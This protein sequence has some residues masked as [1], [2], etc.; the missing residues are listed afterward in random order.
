MESR[1]QR[2]DSFNCVG[3][4]SFRLWICVFV[5]V[6]SYHSANITVETSTEWNLIFSVVVAIT[7]IQS[8]GYTEH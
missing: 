4:I 3:I 2:G 7:I 1:E 6:I 5:I 8:R